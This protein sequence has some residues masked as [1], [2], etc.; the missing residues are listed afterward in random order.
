[1]SLTMYRVREARGSASALVTAGVSK[2]VKL[3]RRAGVKGALFVSRKLR[4]HAKQGVDNGKDDKKD[5]GENSVGRG[6]RGAGCAA[7]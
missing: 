2:T 3:C 5:V 1:M 4:G 6:P 7:G